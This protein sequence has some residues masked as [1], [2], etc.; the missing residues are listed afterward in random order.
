MGPAM[1][2]RA[3]DEGQNSVCRSVPRWRSESLLGNMCAAMKVYI[4]DGVL[5]PG[6]SSGLWMEPWAPGGILG[7]G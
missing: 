4:P 1:K 6:W 7:P 5:N 3:S 2:V